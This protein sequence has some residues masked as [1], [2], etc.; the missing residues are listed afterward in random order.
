MRLNNLAILLLFVLLNACKAHSQ[1]TSDGKSKNIQTISGKKYYIHKVTK[2]QSL[3]AICKIYDS[4]LNSVIVENPDAFDGIKEGQELK[5]PFAKPQSVN[6]DDFET[7]KVAKGETVYAITKKYNITESQLKE[8]N[9]EISSGIKEGQVLKIKAKTKTNTSVTNTTTANT[10]NPSDTV[11]YH[12]VQA[13]ESAYAIS[14][15]YNITLDQLLSWNGLL[16]AD[17]KPGMNLIVGKN[18]TENQ[19]ANN[20]VSNVVDTTK[21]IVNLDKPK[22]QKYNVGLILPFQ[23]NE[24][25]NIDIDYLITNKQNFPS[26][27]S[28]ALDF[29][30]GAIKALD[31]L[32]SNDFQVDFHLFDVGE[33]DSLKLDKTINSSEFKTLDLIIGPMYSSTFKE[34]AKQ[35]KTLQ[36]PIMAPLSAQNKSLYEN[37]YASKLTSSPTTLMELLADYAMD[38][39]SN[40]NLMLV[41]LGIKDSKDLN[42]A[43]AFKNRYNERLHTLK[44]NNLDSIKEVLKLAGVKSNISSTKTNVLVV[45]YNSE[46]VVQDFITQL[47]VFGD[48][49]D[50]IVI[51]LQSWTTRENL[52][53]EYLNTFK[54]T[55]PQFQYIDTKSPI[56]KSFSSN[57]RKT[58]FTDPTDS[59][60]LGFDASY[61]YLK[62]LKEFGPSFYSQL[63]K[64]NGD[65]ISVKYKFYSPSTTTGF[66]NRTFHLLRFDEYKIIKIN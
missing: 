65:G 37:P 57:Y 25:A 56:V 15:K 38:S 58:N 26:Q 14:K 13:G 39:L 21:S 66:E 42:Q 29:Y 51:G 22:K 5:I 55:W 28:L 35:A 31:S 16:P 33:K 53:L 24:S 62:A 50:I 10:T 48:K 34:I 59:Y 20:I 45:P 8:L 41:N 40:T 60:F 46:A 54:F 17:I 2:G 47:N 4:D 7:H 61:Y 52:D 63:N 64:I 36:I 3:Y 9:P 49:K 6:Y 32:K 1:T 27:T 12:L 23:F 19:N 44:G 43:K 30:E 11:K 18:K